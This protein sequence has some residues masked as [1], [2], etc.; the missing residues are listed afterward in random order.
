MTQ[1]FRELAKNI[2]ISLVPG[3]HDRHLEIHRDDPTLGN[4][5][6]PIKIIKP[7]LENGVWYCHGYEFDPVVQYIGW[8]PALWARLTSMRTPG[9]FKSGLVTES[10]LMTVYLI[11]SR[12]ALSIQKKAFKE[13]QTYKGIVLGHTHLPFLH[14]SPQL[15]FLIDD[16]DMRQSATF[17]VGDD[18]GF[19]LIKWDTYQK[20]WLVTSSLQF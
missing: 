17:L 4:P 16:G 13:G 15:P 9:R 6:E 3:N 5:L 12:A 20:R 19:R 14:Q 8:F 7:F 1:K 2:P 10:Y 11:Y 18:K